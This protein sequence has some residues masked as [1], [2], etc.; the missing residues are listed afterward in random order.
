MMPQLVTVRVH[1][2]QGRRIRLWIP[3]LP[4]LIV[5]SPLLIVA[6]VVVAVACL[7]Y[8]VNPVRALGA[9]WG[10]LAGLSGFRL[11]LQQGRTD[12]RVKIT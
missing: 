3:I 9:S 1:S 8:R 11:D 5:L 12:V 6:M 7:L 2:G 10:L 4:I